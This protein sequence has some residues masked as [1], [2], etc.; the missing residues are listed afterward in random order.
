MLDGFQGL[1]RIALPGST[2]A[3]GGSMGNLQGVVKTLLKN[4]PWPRLSA[5][6]LSTQ[7]IVDG[8]IA[9]PRDCWASR[10]GWV[11]DFSELSS[12]G[13]L[14]RR[15]RSTGLETAARARSRLARQHLSGG[16]PCS[17]GQLL[18]AGP[19]QAEFFSGDESGAPWAIKI[20]G[21]RAMTP[22]AERPFEAL[23]RPEDSGE[24][25]GT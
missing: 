24:V 11:A 22:A 5:S 17:Y 23:A 3:R 10:L 18:F 1:R 12:S 13:F 6:W 21:G 16:K 19:F 15:R 25:S 2:L 4:L 14:V 9:R 8:L 7:S 20:P